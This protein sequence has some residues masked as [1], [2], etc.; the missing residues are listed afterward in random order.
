MDVLNNT[1]DT[2]HVSVDQHVCAVMSQSKHDIHAAA[3][4]EGRNDTEDKL[5]TQS[6]NIY[7][8]HLNAT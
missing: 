8:K 4:G 7:F 5:W 1:H 2:F 6:F 3:A